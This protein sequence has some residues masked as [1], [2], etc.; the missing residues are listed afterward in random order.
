MEYILNDQEIDRV[1]QK[2]ETYYSIIELND[3]LYL[4]NKLYRKIETLRNLHNLRTL[5]LNNNALEIISGLD[6]CVNLIALYLNCNKISKIENLDSLTKL[7]I[8]NLE[9][10][11]ICMIE[12]LENLK[13]LEDLNLSN[14]CLGSKSSAH[15]S[16][17][18]KNENLS[19]LNLS[20][21]NID[22]D[23]LKDLSNMKNLSVLYF[24]NNPMLAKY[25]NYRK[26]FL[27]TMKRLTFLDQKPVKMDERRAYSRTSRNGKDKTGETK[28]TRIFGRMYDLHIL[29][30]ARKSLFLWRIKT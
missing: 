10:N 23:I 16:N 6:S 24:M 9:D 25:K 11:N 8:L 2:N 3:V 26:L 1:I 20:N 14:N 22:E 15:V 30:V 21:N 12:N 27:H 19:I 13:L 4:N 5:Y 7:R 18:C 29:H 28:K 17:L